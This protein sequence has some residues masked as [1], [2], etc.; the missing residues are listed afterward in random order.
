MT[1]QPHETKMIPTGIASS[2][3]DDWALIAKER[4]ST[5][6]KGMGLRAGVVDSGYR[7]EIFIALTNE[8]S[9]PVVITKTPELHEG[10]DLI[11]YPYTKAIAQLMLIP[12][13]KAYVK[14]ISYEELQAIPSKRGMGALGSSGK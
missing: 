14:E 9:M 4:G 1:I 8:N 5:G 12:V 11:V 6:T 3:T 10:K 2:V 7:N 13:P